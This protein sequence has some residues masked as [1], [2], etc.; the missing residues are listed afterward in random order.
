MRKTIQWL[1]QKLHSNSLHACANI[2]QSKT[3]GMDLYKEWQT[4]WTTPTEEGQSTEEVKS[5][6]NAMI[7]SSTILAEILRNIFS[8]DNPVMALKF[9]H[10]NAK[11]P[12]DVLGVYT[13]LLVREQFPQATLDVI[14]HDIA[15]VMMFSLQAPKYT[16]FDTWYRR[17][18]QEIENLDLLYGQITWEQALIYTHSDTQILLRVTV[19]VG[20]VCG[21]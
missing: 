11:V 7:Q 4:Y 12:Q 19:S 18:M 16:T 9:H 6:K 8:K 3:E 15:R 2:L 5:V 1:Q 17:F 21:T 10:A 14:V 20:R 13:Y